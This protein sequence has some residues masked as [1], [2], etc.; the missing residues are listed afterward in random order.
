LVW[1]LGRVVELDAHETQMTASADLG[2]I[3]TGMSIASET[4]HAEQTSVAAPAKT[5]IRGVWERSA[6]M[7]GEPPIVETPTAKWNNII[8][9]IADSVP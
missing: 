2:G 5:K 7:L 1:F 9:P 4:A 3:Q 8:G 6:P